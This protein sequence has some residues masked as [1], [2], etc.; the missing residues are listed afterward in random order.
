M[1]TTATLD[2]VAQLVAAFLSSNPVPVSGVPD[3][4]NSVHASIMKLE[5]GN[6][7]GATVL[8]APTPTPLVTIRKS[9]TPNYLISLEDGKRFKS[10]KRH[11]TSLGLT[12]Q[13]YREKWGLP[14]TYPW[15]R[16]V[17]R[18]SDDDGKKPWIWPTAPNAA[19]SQRGPRLTARRAN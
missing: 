7:S 10:L 4:I 2:L 11:L 5:N 13:Q 1:T 3:L 6:E 8:D 17:T 16:P 14:L 19:S 12:P 9:I 15:S 18:R